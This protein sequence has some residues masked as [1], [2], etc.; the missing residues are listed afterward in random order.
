MLVSRKRILHTIELSIGLIEHANCFL[1][2]STGNTNAVIP[3]QCDIW[4]LVLYQYLLWS[5]K[6]GVFT[7][8]VVEG[9][10]PCATTEYEPRTNSAQIKTSCIRPSGK[11]RALGVFKTCCEG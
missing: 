7:L 9:L 8:Q 4:A 1:E 10:R 11:D 5:G 3:G 2:G 6:E